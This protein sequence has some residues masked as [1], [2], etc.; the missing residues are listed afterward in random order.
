LE[1]FDFSCFSN[2]ISIGSDAFSECDEL[3]RINVGIFSDET[4]IRQLIGENREN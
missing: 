4:K 1:E 2:L 3:E